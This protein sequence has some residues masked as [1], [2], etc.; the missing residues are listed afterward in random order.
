MNYSFTFKIPNTPENRQLISDFREVCNKNG[1][2]TKIYGRC[3]NRKYA[4]ESTGRPWNPHNSNHIDISF[5]S[6][7][8][9]FCH[10]WAVYV[11]KKNNLH[12]C[13]KVYRCID[14]YKKVY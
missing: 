4:F 10:S 14:V 7:Q 5:N 9:P 13:D 11:Y 1:L 8:A 2:R 3:K 12:R 6:P